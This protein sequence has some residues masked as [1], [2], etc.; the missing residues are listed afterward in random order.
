MANAVIVFKDY[1]QTIMLAGS[2]MF[3]AALWFTIRRLF[4]GEHMEQDVIDVLTEDFT[5]VIEDR[6][7]DGKIT[8]AEAN[9]AYRR[10]KQLFPTRN[11]YPAVDWLKGTIQK[12]RALHI[13]DPVILP[14]PDKVGK[15]INLFDKKSN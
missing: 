5:S 13:H 3:I 10:L 6:V 7:A 2:V 9:E 4:S 15:K 8:R 11:L 12:R 14:D 1:Q